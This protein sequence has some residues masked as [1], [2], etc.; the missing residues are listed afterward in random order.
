VLAC[1]APQSLSIYS[2]LITPI[3]DLLISRYLPIKII[4]RERVHREGEGEGERKIIV[5][6]E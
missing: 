6:R 1:S 4:Y 5:S 3:Y 2:T